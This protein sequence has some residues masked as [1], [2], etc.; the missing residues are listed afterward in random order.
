MREKRE[1]RH[2]HMSTEHRAHRAHRVTVTE[3]DLFKPPTH[4]HHTAKTVHNCSLNFLSG[5]SALLARSHLSAHRSS[6]CESQDQDITAAR[7]A[8][9]NSALPPLLKPTC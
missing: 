4:Q 1:K 9:H 8:G 2:R 7:Q 6:G 5:S 3:T